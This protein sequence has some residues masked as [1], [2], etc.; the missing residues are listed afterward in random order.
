MKSSCSPSSRLEHRHQS[1]S[2]S[3]HPKQRGRDSIDSIAGSSVSE[4]SS[5]GGN[6]NVGSER[7]KPNAT[8]VAMSLSTSNKNNSGGKTYYTFGQVAVWVAI[9]SSLAAVA[10]ALAAVYA[11]SS[12]LGNG[13]SSADDY[14]LPETA[15]RSRHQQQYDFADRPRLRWATKLVNDN[16]VSNDNH[17]AGQQVLVRL[18]S[19][20]SIGDGTG[21]ASSER[22]KKELSPVAGIVLPPFPAVSRSKDVVASSADDDETNDGGSR[23]PG[24]AWLMS[25]P[26]R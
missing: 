22:R 24:V 19:V 12:A 7:W 14:P 13:G 18:P 5:C 1:C 16:S 10:T 11:F 6:D 15:G 3:S 20:S 9:G 23:H 4:T 21:A 8:A 17:H 2:S 25:F 26:N